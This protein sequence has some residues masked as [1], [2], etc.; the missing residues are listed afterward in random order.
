MIREDLTKRAHLICPEAHFILP[1]KKVVFLMCSIA[2]I[3]T[4]YFNL[5]FHLSS[6]ILL[7]HLQDINNSQSHSPTPHSHPYIP[8]RTLFSFTPF[9]QPPISYTHLPVTL[10][11]DRSHLAMISVDPVYDINSLNPTTHHSVI[12]KC[13]LHFPSQS[14]LLLLFYLGVRPVLRN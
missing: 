9:P 13:S 3:P 14:G 11:L 6:Q 12:R 10:P 2:K 4:Y 1:Q 7:P 8:P 5:P